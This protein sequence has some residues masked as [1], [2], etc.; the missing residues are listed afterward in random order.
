VNHRRRNTGVEADDAFERARAQFS[1][2]YAGNVRERETSRLARRLLIAF[3]M[4]LL[5]AIG[6]YIVLPLFGVVLPAHITLLVFAAIAVGALLAN[7]GEHPPPEPEPESPV[8]GEASER[9]L[10]LGERRDR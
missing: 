5:S 10:R 1:E 4:I 7:E 2:D 6:F 3:G 9:S 8:D